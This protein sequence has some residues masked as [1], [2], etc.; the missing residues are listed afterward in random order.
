MALEA[1]D[2]ASSA[3][4]QML[5]DWETARAEGAGELI[6]TFKDDRTYRWEAFPMNVMMNW[7]AAPSLGLYFNT[8]IRGR[9]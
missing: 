8:D 7:L 1:V 9:Y 5:Y 3:I 2:T 6:V 4:N